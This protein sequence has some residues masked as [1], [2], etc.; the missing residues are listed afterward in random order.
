MS[1]G[2]IEG[3]VTVK[4]KKHLN[5]IKLVGNGPLAVTDLHYQLPD[6]SYDMERN[7]MYIINTQVHVKQW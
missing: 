5:T 1:T 4:T 6:E 7:T 3:T 2:T